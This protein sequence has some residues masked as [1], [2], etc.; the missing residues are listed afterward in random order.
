ML[1]AADRKVYAFTKKKL[2]EERK[3]KHVSSIP[4]I[5]PSSSSSYSFFAGTAMLGS[6]FCLSSVFQIFIPCHYAFRA[7]EREYSEEEE[8]QTKPNSIKVRLSLNQTTK[9]SF[10]SVFIA[11][12]FLRHSI[13]SFAFIRFA[14]FSL[15]WRSCRGVVIHIFCTL[16]NIFA[17]FI[18]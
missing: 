13:R 4:T 10:V 6:F 11:F 3:R 9:Y 1:N 7:S 5:F 8:G 17:A 12:F 14:F 15:H 2:T 18:Q 16:L